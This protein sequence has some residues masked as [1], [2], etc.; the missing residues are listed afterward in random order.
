MFFFFKCTSLTLAQTIKRSLIFCIVFQ[1][2]LITVS[3]YI[4]FTKLKKKYIKHVFFLL[5]GVVLF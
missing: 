5:T 1:S 4:R 2:T 3:I